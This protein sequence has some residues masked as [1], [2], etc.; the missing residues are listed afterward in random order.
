[1]SDNESEV[2]NNIDFDKVA[3]LAC[4]IERDSYQLMCA[5]IS[6]RNVYEMHKN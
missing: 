4:D 2:P 1:M 5:L 6:K 3:G